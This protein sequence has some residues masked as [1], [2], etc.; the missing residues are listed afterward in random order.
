MV[1]P[2]AHLLTSYAPT[3]AI[4]ADLALASNRTPASVGG[5]G[6]LVPVVLS[7]ELVGW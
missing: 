6:G 7:G 1:P 2:R 3:Q 5:S 4:P